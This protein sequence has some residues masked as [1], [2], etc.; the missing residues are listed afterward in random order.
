MPDDILINT[1][2]TPNTTYTKKTPPYLIV[3]E[4]GKSVEHFITLDK[5]ELNGHFAIVKGIYSGA[6]EDDIIKNFDKLLTSAPKEAILE[7]VFPSDKIV[8]IRNLI[9]RAK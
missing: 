7:M 2:T 6:P 9:F 8:R 3:L 1:T 5:P 4:K